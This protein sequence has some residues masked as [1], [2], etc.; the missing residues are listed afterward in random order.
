MLDPP[1]SSSQSGQEAEKTAASGRIESREIADDEFRYAKIP[2]NRFWFLT[3]GVTLGL[4]L[5]MADTSIV[6]TSMYTIGVD[7]Q[8]S[9]QINWIALAYT[10]AYIGCAVTFARISD[11]IGRRD[12]FLVAYVI[13]FGFSLA[14]G[15][16]RNVNEMIIFRVFQGIGGSGKQQICVSK[17]VYLA[18]KGSGLNS[19]ALIM[20]PELAPPHLLQYIGAVIGLVIAMSGVLGPVLGGILTHYADWRWIFWINAPIGLVSLVIFF[21]AWPKKESLPTYEVRKWTSFDVLG[22]FLTLA[23]PTLVVFSFQHA[24]EEKTPNWG[25]AEFLAPLIAGIALFFCLVFWE[26]YLGNRANNRFALAFPV[27]LF[28]NRHYAAGAFSSLA[29]GFPYFIIVFSFPLRTQIV[30]GKDALIAGVM[31]LPMLG[32]TAFGTLAAGRLSSN[33]NRLF[34]TLFVG[35]SLLTL[36]CGLL[37]TVK[38][39]GDDSKALG[40]LVFAG[41]GFGFTASASSMLANVEAPVRD[42]AP[43]QGIISQLRILGG[44]LGISASTLLLQNEIRQHLVGLLTAEQLQTLGHVGTPLTEIQQ[45][46]LE[47]AYSN[48][49]RNG[50]LVATGVAGLG[51][52]TTLLA[53]R[54]ERKNFQE[55]RQQRVVEERERRRAERLA[56]QATAPASA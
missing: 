45:E 16:A 10:L 39:S 36:G 27:D 42:F 15:F 5:A 25:H 50:M 33:T 34:E 30:S 43:A 41:L 26:R 14:C 55:Q 47:M 19:L 35:A 23:A 1:E 11:I 28:K 53:F 12:A 4:F 18:H 54:R 2:V 7:F 40:F 48:M 13:F 29:L 9:D 51:I 3:L 49:F 22:S 20:L 6:A 21:L 38:G 8:S 56:S 32:S 17:S 31:L 46:A 24:G 52:L 37:S 44:S